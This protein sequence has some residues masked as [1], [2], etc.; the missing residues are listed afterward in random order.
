MA[1]LYIKDINGN[2]VEVPSIRGAKGDRGE[3]GV[4]G[5]KGDKGDSFTYEDLTEEQKAEICNIPTSQEI[6]DMVDEVWDS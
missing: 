5:E 1:I 2:L 6:K 4:K 3:Q